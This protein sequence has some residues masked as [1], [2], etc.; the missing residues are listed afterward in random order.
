MLNL[1][2][3]SVLPHP[4]GELVSEANSSTHSLQRV[5]NDEYDHGDGDDVVVGQGYDLQMSL[6][7]IQRSQE[8]YYL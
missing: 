7:C 4:G 3:N 6:S 8:E 2:P 1:L 5:S